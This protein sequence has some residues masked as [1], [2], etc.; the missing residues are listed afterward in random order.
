VAVVADPAVRIFPLFDITHAPPTCAPLIVD[1]KCLF[2]AGQGS[3]NFN[4]SAC[5]ELRIA[6]NESLCL[7]EATAAHPD[8]A[9]KVSGYRRRSAGFPYADPVANCA[10]TLKEPALLYAL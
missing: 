5:F 7:I 8:I 9:G 10:T 2:R 6:S 3:A 4:C 1:P